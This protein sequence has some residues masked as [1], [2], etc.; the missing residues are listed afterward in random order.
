MDI[1]TNSL[2]YNFDSEGNTV[3]ATVSFT[4]QEGSEYLNA[5]MVVE[6]TDLA[7]GSNFDDLTK[8]EITILARKK[9]DA[10]TAA[11]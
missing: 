10:A 11:E 3:S 8:K 4:G 7:E 1:K 6:K 5:N 2:A 9:L